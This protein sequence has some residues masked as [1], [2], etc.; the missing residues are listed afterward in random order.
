[1]KLTYLIL[2][3]L[4][5]AVATGCQRRPGDLGDD[6]IVTE[7]VD[8]AIADGRPGAITYEGPGEQ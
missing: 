4:L 1:M 8:D 5:F 7:E 3:S 6:E 2:L